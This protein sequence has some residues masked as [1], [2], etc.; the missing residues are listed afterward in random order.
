[1]AEMTGWHLAILA[2]GSLGFG[3]LALATDRQGELL[4]GRLP[5]PRWRR[6]ARIT[7]WALLAVALVVSVILWGSGVGITLFLGWLTIAGAALVFAI[8][9][10]SRLPQRAP[11]P[12]RKAGAAVGKAAV[13]AGDAA[14]T[15]SIAGQGGASRAAGAAAMLARQP[16]RLVPALLLALTVAVFVTALIRAQAGPLERADAVHG[17]V[18]PWSLILAEADRDPPEIVDLEVPLKAFRIRFCEACDGDIRFAFLKVNQPRSLRAAGMGFEGARW[19][20]RVEI[21]LPATVNADSELW[22]TVVGKDGSVHQT[23]WP[24]SRVSPASV[25]WFDNRMRK[26][27]DE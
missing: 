14:A 22:L 2:I 13:G 16:R 4:L 7:G 9:R 10:W 15:A 1:M 27:S 25:A 23:S 20:R 26:Q 18:G 24:L 12:A 11:R 19:E 17:K 5:A 8:P 3:A 21:Q 6:L